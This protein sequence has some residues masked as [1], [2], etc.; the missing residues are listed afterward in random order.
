MEKCEINQV[1]FYFITR[2]TKVYNVQ[3]IIKNV[4]IQM[5]YNDQK[6]SKQKSKVF[7]NDGF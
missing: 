2:F 7:L 1:Y 3:N 5:F 4:F 6:C